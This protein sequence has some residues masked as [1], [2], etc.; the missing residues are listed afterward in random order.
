MGIL[1]KLEEKEKAT[2]KKGAWYYMFNEERYAGLS[3]NG[4]SFNLDV[5]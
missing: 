1:E 2:S 4:F 3:K 5:N